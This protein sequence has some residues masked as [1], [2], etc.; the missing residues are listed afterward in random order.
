MVQWAH[1][2]RNGTR[3]ASCSSLSLCVGLFLGPALTRQSGAA[4]S[5][6][7]LILSPSSSDMSSLSSPTPFNLLSILPLR[8][9]PLLSFLLLHLCTM[10]PASQAV[11]SGLTTHCPCQL[12][13]GPASS[14]QIHMSIVYTPMFTSTLITVPSRVFRMCGFFSSSTTVCF[15]LGRLFASK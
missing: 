5:S 1:Q 7:S 8:I 12:K 9:V 6:S 13:T 11:E 3:V 15:Q 14:R 2:S 10:L 4:Y